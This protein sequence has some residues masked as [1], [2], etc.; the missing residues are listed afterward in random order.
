[1][2]TLETNSMSKHVDYDRI[3]P[4]YNQRYGENRRSGT[5]TALIS[6]VC[7]LQ[8]ERVLEVGCGTGHWLAELKPHVPDVFGLDLSTG[9]LRQARET[10]PTGLVRG[11]G[12]MLGLAPDSLDLVYCVN[13]IHHFAQPRAFVAEARRLLRPGGVLAVI[14][15]DPRAE[16]EW[17]VFHYFDEVY[18]TDLERFPSWGTIVDWMVASGFSDIACRV[19]DR[20]TDPKFGRAVLD[21][22]F[23][24]KDSCSQLALL[25]DDAYARGVRRIEAALDEAETAGIELVFQVDTELE[26]LTGCAV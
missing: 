23:L 25:S 18:E 2:S 20:Y 22:P 11:R 24:K 4:S 12:G 10:G 6:L 21:D 5:A 8:A 26:M 1:M 15:M 13:A 19:V 17:Y 7:D 3:A 9:M 16:P 14:G